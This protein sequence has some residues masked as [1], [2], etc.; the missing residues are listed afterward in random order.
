MST[1]TEVAREYP[2]PRLPLGTLIRDPQLHRR[3]AEAWKRRGDVGRYRLHLGLADTYE[4]EDRR[5]D[6]RRRR[7]RTSA[8]SK[9]GP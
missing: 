4:R 5:G 7:Q 8:N 6:Q 9:D 2:P 3:V 1:D